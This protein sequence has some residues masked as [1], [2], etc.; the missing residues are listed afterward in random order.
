M[1][2]HADEPRPSPPTSALPLLARG[3]TPGKLRGLRRISH[4]DGT[5]TILA[6]DHGEPMLD[7]MRAARAD[8]GEPR[9]P[10]FGEVVDAKLELT[11]ALAPATSGVLIDAPYGAWAAIATGAVPRDRG[12]LL[13]LEGDGAPRSAAGVPLMRIDA[14][15]SVEKI[16]LAGGDAV[17]LLAPF[18][19][20]DPESAEH[21]LALIEQVAAECR[22]YDLLF[23]LEPISVPLRGESATTASYLDRKPGTVLESARLLSRHCD[24]YKA[25]FPGTLDRDAD[26]VLMDALQALGS[27]CERPWVL[28]SAGVGFETFLEQVRMAAECGASGVLAGRAFWQEYFHQPDP[29]ARA[30]FAAVEALRRVREVDAIVRE[31]ATPWFERLG[32]SPDD[33]AAIRPAEGWQFRYAPHAQAA[34]GPAGGGERG[35]AAAR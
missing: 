2:P 35:D 23:L 17:K 22:R 3:L 9:E 25:E 13:R 6:L 5:L 7:L 15:W 20:G 16:K 31:R 28:L 10:A 29:A 24:V 18:E 8:R 12:L 33:L 34:P 1:P 32:L 19:P 11:R 14:G 30:E 27:V 21:Q 4:D 26:D